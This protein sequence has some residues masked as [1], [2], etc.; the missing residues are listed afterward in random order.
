[1]KTTLSLMLLS[2]SLLCCRKEKDSDLPFDKGFLS[3]NVEVDIKINE[4]SPVLK[5]TFSIDDFLVIIYK[6]NGEEVKRYE[7]AADLPSQIELKTGVYYVAASSKNMSPAA[8]ENPYYY[9]KSE[10]FTIEVSNTKYVTVPC[11]LANCAVSIIYSENVKAGFSDYH[12]EI[13][14]VNGSLLFEKNEE[15]KGYFEIMPINIKATLLYNFNGE[16]RSKT[17]TGTIS[18]PSPGKHYEVVFDAKLT[19]GASSFNILLDSLETKEQVNISEGSPL[20][21]TEVMFDPEAI[22]EPSGEWFELY[23]NSNSS[24]NLK[25][26]TILRGTQKHIINRDVIINPFNYYAFARSEGAFEGEKYVYGTISLPNTSATLAVL[27][28]QGTDTT[29]IASITYGTPGFPSAPGTSINLSTN[30]Y[31]SGE[32]KNSAS[33]CPSSDSYN[34]GDLGTP[35]LPNKICD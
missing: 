1:M 34:T 14:T 35:G 29:E 21:I 10:N 25:G 23:N 9:G 17:L 3:I 6:E 15:R 30:H 32:A 4:I 5:S 7:R 31:N 13:S 33:W 18:T 27:D 19:H 22:S 12:T 8:F 11:K 28:I 24:V 2:F 20:L 26:F 16:P